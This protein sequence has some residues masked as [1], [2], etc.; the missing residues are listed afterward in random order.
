MPGVAPPGLV[1]E[2]PHVTFPDDYQGALLQHRF[3]FRNA[4]AKPVLVQSGLAISGTGTVRF[5]PALVAPGARGAAYVTQP[6]QGLGRASFRFAL[7]T[8]EPGVARYRMSL[9]G[10][11]QSA[12]DPEVA[13]LDF[14]QLERGQTGQAT[15]ELFSREVDALR[16]LRISGAPAY[17]DVRAD[18][19]A[20]LA[21]EGVRVHATLRPGAPLGVTS[22]T[23]RLETNVGAQ[24]FY[25]LAYTLRIFGDVQPSE[26]PIA[27]GLLRAGQEASGEVL[28]RSR[29]GV[30]VSVLSAQ[31]PS[32]VVEAHSQPCGSGCARLVLTAY[33]E[34]T[35]SLEGTLDVRLAGS[36]EPLPLRYV[37]WVVAPQTEVRTLDFA[38]PGL[39]LATPTT[40]SSERVL[41]SPSLP[42][43]AGPT[44]TPPAEPREPAPLPRP[45]SEV[46]LE[47]KARNDR[48]AQGYLVYRSEHPEG[49]FRRVSA[50]M[51]PVSGTDAAVHEYVFVDKAVQ[52]GR[53]YH[54]YLDLVGIDGRKRRFS[55][56]QTRQVAGAP[57]HGRRPK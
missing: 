53:A 15:L 36:D 56:V 1:I 41:A 48:E 5:E 7:I 44:P 47:W 9:S 29:S 8:D 50:T 3:E 34:T 40:S 49:P 38:P 27:F 45:A 30:A 4:S 57:D 19:R 17:L 35:G 2:Q 13:R 21:D 20:G 10:F 46:R 18:A 33:T 16:V 12:Y 43:V 39:D 24:P 11:I 23:L 25:E 26:Q 52:A 54:Y 28:L 42:S 51:V 55:G 6:L 22:G 32:G 14:G 37:G 31:D